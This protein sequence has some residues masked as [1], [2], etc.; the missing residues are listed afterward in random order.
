LDG[1][2]LYTVPT[3][4]CPIEIPTRLRIQLNL[5]AGQLYISSIEEYRE[6][7]D[8]LGVAS[9]IPPEGVTVAA[10]G[11]ILAGGEH[12]SATFTK[13][14]LKFL[15]MHLSQ[16]RKNGQDIDK[17]HLGKLVD[18]KLLCASDF[19]DCEDTQTTTDN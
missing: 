19:Q 7:C 6:I 8:F 4:S 16:I 5:F 14:P 13:S 1:L 17:T 10:D 2:N 18:G 15:K 11:F 9:T 3:V 12:S